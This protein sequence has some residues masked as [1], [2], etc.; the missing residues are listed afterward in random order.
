[1][2]SD[3][4]AL[5]EHRSLLLHR[6]VARRIDLDS[7]IVPRAL[8]RVATAL[9]TGRTHREYA[10]AWQAALIG[11]REM[12]FALLLDEGERATAMRQATPFPFVVDAPTRNRLWR[13]AKAQWE[14]ARAPC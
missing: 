2:R 4:H 9:E 3:R 11:P 10:L 12:L 6:E 8:V 1:M 5:A 13:E 7:S 14:A